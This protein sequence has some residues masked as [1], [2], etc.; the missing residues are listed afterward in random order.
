MCVAAPSVALAGPRIASSAAKQS[1][2]LFNRTV[3][4]TPEPSQRIVLIE[5]TASP[6]NDMFADAVLAVILKAETDGNK[7]K[8]PPPAVKIGLYP[9]RSR[10]NLTL[11]PPVSRLTLSVKGRPPLAV[12]VLINLSA[13]YG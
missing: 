9:L 13:S 7:G 5:W 1:L 12:N 10:A 8:P 2:A 6:V 4:V 3:T 11:P